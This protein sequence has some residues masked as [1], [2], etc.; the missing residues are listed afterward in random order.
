MA[1]AS[2]PISYDNNR[3][4]FDSHS[5]PAPLPININTTHSLNGTELQL[6]FYSKASNITYRFRLE[7]PEET[8]RF[9]GTLINKPRIDCTL[10]HG[11]SVKVLDSN[12]KVEIL[13]E[14]GAELEYFKTYVD[15]SGFN[16]L[17]EE[18]EDGTHLLTLRPLQDDRLTAIKGLFF[19]IKQNAFHFFDN[20]NQEDKPALKAYIKIILEE[21]PRLIEDDPI[22]RTFTVTSD[23]VMEE[24]PT[25]TLMTKADISALDAW[26]TKPA[27]AALEL[28]I[29]ATQAKLQA[30]QA[31][32]ADMKQ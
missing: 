31:Q 2:F 32:L 13:F 24:G 8:R 3:L 26:I 14:N 15:L 1:S 4:Q 7:T 29:A 18:K 27:K 22:S 20:L 6:T 19:R 11:K 5:L 12:Q 16:A 21:P 30:L 17:S 28:E 9:I 25:R 23:A 10:Y